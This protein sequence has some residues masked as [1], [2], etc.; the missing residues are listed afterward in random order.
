MTYS[1][2]RHFLPASTT[3]LTADQWIWCLAAGISE[4]FLQQVI[5]TVTPFLAP[6]RVAKPEPLTDAELA[7]HASVGAALV[8]KMESAKYGNGSAFEKSKR[9]TRSAASNGKNY[10]AKVHPGPAGEKAAESV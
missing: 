1:N 9:V 6:G 5:I 4:L 10:E 2:N 8:A 3:H 7:E